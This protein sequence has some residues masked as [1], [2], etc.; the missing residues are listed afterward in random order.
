MLE[1]GPI[2]IVRAW[3]SVSTMDE[4]GESFPEVMV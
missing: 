3:G 2:D 4:G 1:N